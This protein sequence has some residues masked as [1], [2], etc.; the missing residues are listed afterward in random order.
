MSQGSKTT[1]YG[2]SDILQCTRSE[3][4]NPMWPRELF[5]GP[6]GSMGRGGEEGGLGGPR[7]SRG[8]LGDPMGRSG[9]FDGSSDDS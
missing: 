6:R 8:R 3:F 1:F 2:S 5:R 7:V 4:K 9:W